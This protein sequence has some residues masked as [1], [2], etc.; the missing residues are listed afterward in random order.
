EYSQLVKCPRKRQRFLKTNSAKVLLGFGPKKP[1]IVVHAEVPNG[2]LWEGPALDEPN[3]EIPGRF[4]PLGV[5]D[6]KPL[7]SVLPPW[8]K[9]NVTNIGVM[10]NLEYPYKFPNPPFLP[11]K[12]TPEVVPFGREEYR[13][14]EKPMKLD[15]P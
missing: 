4:P 7:D 10:P 8:F 2:T 13:I 5:K 1:P 14:Q 3:K 12:E 11:N 9:L 15:L 6:V